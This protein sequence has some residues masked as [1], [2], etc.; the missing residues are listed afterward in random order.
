MNLLNNKIE[1]DIISSFP[2]LKDLK[3]KDNYYSYKYND[4]IKMKI[5]IGKED[6]HLNSLIALFRGTS[7]GERQL[8][9]IS[10]KYSKKWDNAFTGYLFY[11]ET[12]GTNI[13]VKIKRGTKKWE[14]EKQSKVRGKYITLEQ[15]NKECVKKH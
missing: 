9:I 3:E 2:L 1:E 15:I 13:L 6:T 4:L 7:V 12:D 11:K 8:L 14:I 5:P 10:D